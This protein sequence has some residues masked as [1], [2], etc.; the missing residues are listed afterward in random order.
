[1]LLGKQKL[2]GTSSP[3]S[4]WQKTGVS[5]AA[6]QRAVLPQLSQNLNSLWQLVASDRAASAEVKNKERKKS[7]ENGSNLEPDA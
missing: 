6:R 3:R 1:L 4:D 7:Y 5:C 2:S